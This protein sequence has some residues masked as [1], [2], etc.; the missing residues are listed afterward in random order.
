MITI[1]V[2]YKT[3]RYK[4]CNIFYY[5]TNGRKT[6]C[7]FLKIFLIPIK[8][9]IHSAGKCFQYLFNLLQIKDR[10]N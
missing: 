7:Q 6:N 10:L 3:K 9:V 4:Y 5:K 2:F 8:T 1:I